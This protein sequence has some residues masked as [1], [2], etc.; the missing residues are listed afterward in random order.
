MRDVFWW[1]S[2]MAGMDTRDTRAG[3]RE[4]YPSAGRTSVRPMLPP[5]EVTTFNF[6]RRLVFWQ[7]KRGGQ[8]AATLHSR[9]LEGGLKGRRAPSGADLELAVEVTSGRWIDLLLQAKRIYE[10]ALGDPGIYAGWKSSQIGDL[11][12][13]ARK[14]HRTPGMLLYNAEVSPFG[15]FQTDVTLGGCCK[16]SLTCYGSKWPPPGMKKNGSPLAIT[17]VVLSD[18]PAQLPSPLR[19]DSLPAD[20]VNQFAAP[21]E[22]ILCPNRQSDPSSTIKKTDTSHRISPIPLSPE[23]PTWANNLMM[24]MQLRRRNYSGIEPN[25][26]EEEHDA[27]FSLVLPLPE[28]AEY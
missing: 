20:V 17:F 22:C 23:I 16:G 6:I 27:D 1:C 28:D 19:G 2:A 25:L 13:W 9:A 21:I 26:R 12:R 4:R 14:E 5:E 8:A 11:R 24:A 7:R 10:P 15:G 18:L 3:I